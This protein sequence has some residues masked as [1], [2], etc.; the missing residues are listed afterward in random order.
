MASRRVEITT[1]GRGGTIS[2]REGRNLAS[3]DWEFGGG[4]ALAI[5]IGPKSEHWDL[6]NPWATGRQAE[7]YEFV[8]AEV[9]RQQAPGYSAD[10][11][12]ANGFVTILKKIQE[13]GKV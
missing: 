3:F 11:D 8:G 4:D 2:Y 5:L 13:P 10:I 12:L 9:I 7:I 1:S 6:Q